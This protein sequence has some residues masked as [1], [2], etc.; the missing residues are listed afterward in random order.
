MCREYSVQLSG[1]NT[2]STDVKISI[3]VFICT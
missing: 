1:I 2:V 3:A